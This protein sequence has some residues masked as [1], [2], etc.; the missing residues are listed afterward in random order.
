AFSPDGRHLVSAGADGTARVHE[1]G[2]GTEL[3]SLR[4]HSG[5]VSCVAYSPDGR[6]II[7]AVGD[8]FGQNPGGRLKG[9][10]K[11]WDARTGQELRA[12]EGRSHH[13]HNLA[14]SPDGQRLVA[15]GGEWGRPEIIVWDLKA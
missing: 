13:V 6:T 9:E 14:L 7:S 15:V 8:F 5:P 3:L 12:L 11:I 1:V 4:E 10:V 2:T